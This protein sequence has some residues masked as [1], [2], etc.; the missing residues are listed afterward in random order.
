MLQLHGRKLW[1]VLPP[2]E[3]SHLA[4]VPNEKK[5][6]THYLADV[7]QPASERNADVNASLDAIRTIFEFTLAPG[8]L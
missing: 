6:D 3:T 4:G 2:R 5:T 7:L 1:R 8:E